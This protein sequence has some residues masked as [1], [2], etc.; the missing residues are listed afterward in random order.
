MRSSL[1]G[2]DVGCICTEKDV[3]AHTQIEARPLSTPQSLVAVQSIGMAK[4][5]RK[6]SC[7]LECSSASNNQE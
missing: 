1:F 2:L 6:T 3:N 7:L 4:V 5:W